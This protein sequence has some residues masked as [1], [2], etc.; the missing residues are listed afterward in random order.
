M[1]FQRKEKLQ[2]KVLQVSVDTNEKVMESPRG[3][4]PRK[5]K[6]NNNGREI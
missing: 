6:F 1:N 4:G 3:Q 5:S 2:P